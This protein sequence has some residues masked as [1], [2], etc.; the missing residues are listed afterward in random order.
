MVTI[1]QILNLIESIPG[2][3]H[4]ENMSTQ[5]IEFSEAKN[6]ENQWANLIISLP[7]LKTL[8]VGTR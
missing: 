5:Y 2:Y 6:G 8:I 4:Y 1:I 7:L 3:S